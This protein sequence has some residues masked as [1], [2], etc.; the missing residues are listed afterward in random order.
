MKRHP[1]WM[2]FVSPISNILC[3]LCGNTGEVDTRK[4]AA[5]PTGM[6]CGM[7]TFCLCPHGPSREKGRGS[8]KKSSEVMM[9]Y[10]SKINTGSSTRA[11]TGTCSIRPSIA[12]LK[13]S[14]DGRE[15]LGSTR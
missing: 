6:R 1:L 5:S 10:Q 2:E 9:Q 7:K 14:E 4:S 12:S 8:T 13:A 3:G 11:V 15:V